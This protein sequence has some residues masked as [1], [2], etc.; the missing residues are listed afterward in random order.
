LSHPAGQPR[1][2]FSLRGDTQRIHDS[3]QISVDPSAVGQPAFS[4]GAPAFASQ[5]QYRLGT[6]RSCGLQIAQTVTDYHGIDQ[7]QT[8]LP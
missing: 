1:S 2:D 5:H 6:N 7:R 3:C 4:L 8:Q